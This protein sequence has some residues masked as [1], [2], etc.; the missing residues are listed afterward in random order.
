[1]EGGQVGVDVGHGGVH[2]LVVA[3]DQV[4]TPL[5]HGSVQF[6]ERCHHLAAG[7]H[8]MKHGLRGGGSGEW[9]CWVPP[10]MNFRF[11]SLLKV[12]R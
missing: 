11:S 5:Q 1:V 12:A 2:R 8:R 7:W 9:L 3:G 4:D 10:S 6:V